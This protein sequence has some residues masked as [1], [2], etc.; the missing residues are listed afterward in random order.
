MFLAFILLFSS[1]NLMAQKDEETLLMEAYESRDIQKLNEFIERFSPESKYVKEAIRVRNQI[2][3]EKAKQENTL[4]AYREFEKLYPNSLQINEVRMWIAEQTLDHLIDGGSR[5]EIKELMKKTSNP[6]ILSKAEQELERLCYEESREKN[7]IESYKTYLQRYPNGQYS[8]IA[9]QSLEELEYEKYVQTYDVDELIYFLSKFPSHP[10]HSEVYFTLLDISMDLNSLVGIKHIFSN[11]RYAVL[12]DVLEEFMREYLSTGWESAFSEFLLEFP[13]YKE[14]EVF[15]AI[16][17]DAK[18]VERLMALPSIN[19]NVYRKNPEYFNN[20]VNDNNLNLIKKYHKQLVAQR[21]LTQA[22]Q[23][24]SSFSYDHRVNEYARMFSEKPSPEPSANNISFSKDSTVMVYSEAKLNNYGGNDLYL[25]FKKDS[26]TKSYLLPSTI[27]SKYE[28]ISPILSNDG[29][30]LYFYSNNGMN[31]SEYDLY[32]SFNIDPSSTYDNPYDWTKPIKANT[33]NLEY[34]QEEYIFGR[35]INQ[36][37]EAIEGRVFID[38]ITTGRNLGHTF[39]DKKSGGF[40][41]L[42]PDKPVKIIGVSPNCV[43]I[44]EHFHNLENLTVHEVSDMIEKRKVLTIESI[45]DTPN[46]LSKYSQRYLEYM[47]NSLKDLDHTITIS[48]HTQNGYKDMNESELS[49][50]QAS[51][52]K[53]ELIKYGYPSHRIVVAGYGKESP[54]IGWEGRDR[55]EIGF[56]E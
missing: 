54:L 14:N 46:A 16:L 51:L 15:N 7:T 43:P 5:E 38:E 11:N 19:A 32:I 23:Y 48:V 37:G 45:F 44:I 26:Y 20:I 1:P 41:M 8:K 34:T 33:L 42:K 10:K 39:S 22:K 50:H 35:L 56:I 31:I 2:A 6:E 52:I 18:N 30:A 27:N 28:E 40:A 47:A 9:K 13:K 25:A 3:Y 53:S 12:V 29:R 36:D 24:I 4:E 17:T 49:S 55:I 21:K